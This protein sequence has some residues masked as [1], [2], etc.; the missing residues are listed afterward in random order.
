MVYYVNYGQLRSFDL[1]PILS[2]RSEFNH[3]QVII[4]KDPLNKLVVGKNRETICT[5]PLNLDLDTITAQL[6]RHI[7]IEDAKKIAI[8]VSKSLASKDGVFWT[9]ALS[10]RY[11]EIPIHTDG[12]D[13]SDGFSNMIKKNLKSTG[14]PHELPNVFQDA[15]KQLNQKE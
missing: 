5:C 13:T 12:S 1:A 9:R 6:S 2:I 7:P 10:D 4:N 11:A 8:Q 3:Y 15:Q 14:P